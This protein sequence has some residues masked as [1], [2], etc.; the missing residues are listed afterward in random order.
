MNKEQANP[1]SSLNILN[2]VVN[3]ISKKY[4]NIPNILN[5]MELHPE[6]YTPWFT[7]VM[8]YKGKYMDDVLNKRIE[9]KGFDGEIKNFM[10]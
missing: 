4:I 5:D 3:N 1:F 6:C 8:K 7:I 10:K 2:L 9:F